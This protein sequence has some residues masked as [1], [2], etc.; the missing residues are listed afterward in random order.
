MNYKIPKNIL[1]ICIFICS[2]SSIFTVQEIGIRNKRS[3]KSLLLNYIDFIKLSG[4]NI[5]T[6][7]RTGSEYLNSK[8]E[9]LDNFSDLIEPEEFVRGKDLINKLLNDIEVSNNDSADADFA[10]FTNSFMESSN[11]STFLLSSLL[12]FLVIIDLCLIYLLFNN[13]SKLENKT[14]HKIQKYSIRFLPEEYIND[15]ETI[16][17]RLQKQKLSDEE[18]ET[19]ITLSALAMLRGYLICKLQDL[20]LNKNRPE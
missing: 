19:E 13:D 11:P 16:R 1:L 2:I 7:A 12:F 9:S 18:I 8:K 14:K 20:W 3:K 10:A 6:A 4:K 15:L 5:E 17:Q